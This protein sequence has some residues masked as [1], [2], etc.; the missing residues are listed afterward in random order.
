MSPEADERRNMS[1]GGSAFE[2][3]LTIKR[4]PRHTWAKAQS[5]AT[6]WGLK[7]HQDR[8]KLILRCC[9]T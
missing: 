9:K 7:K 5:L 3:D 4:D 6:Q 2:C 1:L 8:K